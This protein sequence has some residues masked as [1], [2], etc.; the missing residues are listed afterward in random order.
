MK[1]L[2]LPLVATTLATLISASN[3]GDNKTDT[4]TTT[5][6]SSGSNNGGAFSL[7]SQQ[8]LLIASKTFELGFS[9]TAGH[10]PSPSDIQSFIEQYTNGAPHNAVTYASLVAVAAALGGM[11]VAFA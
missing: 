8:K 6:T 3:T 5:N 7:D 2:L 10:E 4:T 11:V 1:F 9:L